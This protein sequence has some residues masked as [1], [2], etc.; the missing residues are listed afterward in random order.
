MK[1]RFLSC[2][3]FLFPVM[4]SGQNVVDYKLF[5]DAAQE[6]S[7]LFR[8]AF[9]LRFGHPVSHDGSTF[10]AYAT[11]YQAGTLVFCKKP[12]KDVWLN[13]NAFTD[14]LYIMDPAT[15]IPVLMNKD[16]VDSFTMGPHKFVCYK[17][18]ADSPLKEGYYETLYSGR[19][20]LFK[21]IQKLLREE[22]NNGNRILRRYLLSE[23]FYLQKNNTW[24]RI[25]SKTDVIKLFPEQKK[26]I[27][28]IAK[29]KALDFRRNKHKAFMEI[30]TYI[31][32][33]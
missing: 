8:G 23:T 11:N 19:I 12:Y 27:D 28:H 6:H 29:T 10:F 4:L 26:L 3:I 33:L 21:K 2:L 14:D 24:Y 32:S 7:I 25:N 20:L 15:G 1:F 5:M 30:C 16:F 17:P 9:P 22:N 31:D 13:L 18:D